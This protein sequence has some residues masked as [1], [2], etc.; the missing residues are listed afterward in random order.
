LKAAKGFWTMEA[1]A[2]SLYLLN[3]KKLGLVFYS[4]SCKALDFRCWEGLEKHLVFRFSI[5]ERKSISFIKLKLKE[6]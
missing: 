3:L 1:K 6:S 4:L 5:P 2:I